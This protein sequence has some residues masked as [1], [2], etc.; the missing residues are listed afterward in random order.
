MIRTAEEYR[1]TN[2]QAQDYIT[3]VVNGRL[4]HKSKYS[5]VDHH[6]VK[7]FQI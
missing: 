2:A 4:Q 7:S 1:R 6:R 5:T 3:L